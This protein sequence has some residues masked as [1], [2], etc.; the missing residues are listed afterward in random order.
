MIYSGVKL[1]RVDPRRHGGSTQQGHRRGWDEGRSPQARGKRGLRQQLEVGD[2]SIPAGTGEAF[3]RTRVTR[4]GGVDPRRH[5]GSG[6]PRYWQQ[7]IKGRSPQARG[8]RAASGLLAR[9]LGSIPAGTGE[10][11]R[12]G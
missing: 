5:G 9:L 6:V 11:H 8:K 12:P 10:A 3:P 7:Q 1:W 2:G 4:M